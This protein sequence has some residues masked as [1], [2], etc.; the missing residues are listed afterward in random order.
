MEEDPT[1]KK[2]STLF[3]DNLKLQKMQFLSLHSDLKTVIDDID[4]VKNQN[5]RLFDEK[6]PAMIMLTMNNK[7]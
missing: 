2:L 6:L 5:E 3:I 1:H 7:L 4:T